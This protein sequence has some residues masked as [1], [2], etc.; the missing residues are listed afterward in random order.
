MGLFEETMESIKSLPIRDF[1]TQAINFGMI[2]VSALMIYRSLM[3]ITGS[4]SP[5]VVVL[6]GSMEPG[7]ARGDILLLHMN[8]DRIRAG[9]IVVFKVNR[10]EIPIVH[11]V[12]QVHERRDTGV[13]DVLTKGDNNPGDDRPFYAHRQL[14]LQQNHIVGRAVGFV[15][16]LGWATILLNENPVIK[17]ILIGTLGC[18]IIFT[19]D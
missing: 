1:L 10:R 17:Y 6:S 3:I 15:P 13:V 9:D 18:V 12:I 4:E 16:Y 14:W 7:F 11:R 5:V 19:K 2:V 8:K